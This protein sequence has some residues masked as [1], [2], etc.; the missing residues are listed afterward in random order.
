MP[1]TG[2]AS[3]RRADRTV[4]FTNNPTLKP[5]RTESYDIGVE[6]R[7]LSGRLSLDATWFRNRYKDLIVGL[8]RPA[9]ESFAVPNR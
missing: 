2:L 7:C 9:V 4:A 8:G 6:E 1:P 5:E 3:G